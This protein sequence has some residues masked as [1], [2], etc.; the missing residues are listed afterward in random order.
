MS[1]AVVVSLQRILTVV[2]HPGDG[3]HGDVLSIPVA[4]VSGEDDG[5]LSGSVGNQVGTAVSDI[6]GGL[7]V[8]V[9]LSLSVVVSAELTALGLEV[10]TVHGSEHAVA[11]HGVEEGAFLRQGVLQGVGIN[12]LNTDIVEVGGLAVDVLIGTNDA[13][14]LVS[15]VLQAAC[16][17][18]HVLHTGDEVVSGDLSDLTALGV[19][20]LSA[21]TQDEG[22]GLGAVFVNLLGPALS[23]SGLQLVLCIVLYQAVVGVNNSFGVSS[24]GGCQNVPSLRIGRVTEGVGVLQGVALTGQELSSPVAVVDFVFSAQLS[25]LCLHLVAVS[26]QQRL[27][28]DQNVVVTVGVVAPQSGS[29]GVGSN[30]GDSVV[31]A[32]GAQG[33]HNAGTQQ[34]SLSNSHQ[35]MTLGNGSCILL[36]IGVNFVELAQD[37]FVDSPGQL[38]VVL[39]V[40]IRIYVLNRCI[41]FGSIGCRGLCCGSLGFSGSLGFAAGDQTQNH[42]QSQKQSN[43]LLGIH[44]QILL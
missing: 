25:P 7:A 3:L 33:Q 38:V 42:D 26:G 20:P 14:S 2:V 5:V 16:C 4:G 11:Q 30:T 44:F 39:D 23:Q 29:S 22:P 28:S 15:Q 9:G 21:L 32:V 31:T 19:N 1:H 6:I 18:H 10:L 17:V 27:G 34:L 43:D 8:G 40:S 35:S 13:S 24:H 12:S 37:V 36:S 41:H